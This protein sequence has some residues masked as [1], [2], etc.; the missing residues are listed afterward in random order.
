MTISRRAM[1]RPARVIEVDQADEVSLRIEPAAQVIVTERTERVTPSEPA[2]LPVAAPVPARRRDRVVSLALAGV[3][4]FFVGWL[5]VDALA[6]IAA[7]FERGTALGLL[8][9][10]AV[11]AGVAGAGAVIARE[12]Q[13]VPAQE[14][15]EAIHQ[16]LAGNLDRLRRP[17]RARRLPTCWRWCRASARSRPRSRRSSG[18]GHCIHS[19]G[20]QIE[21]LSR[22]VMTPLDRRAEAHVRTAVL[23]AFGITAISPTALTDA[24]FFLACG[25]RMVRGIASAYGHRPTA[26]ST[27][28]GGWSTRPASSAPSTSPAPAWCNTSAARSPSGSPPARPMRSTPATGWRGSASSSWICAGRFRSARTRFQC[29]LAGRQ[30][31]APRTERSLPRGRSRMRRN[32]MRGGSGMRSRISL[33][34]IRTTG[35]VRRRNVAPATWFHFTATA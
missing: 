5:A 13:P 28:C 8:A 20:Q 2:Y 18:E 31:A 24:A 29:R 11:A 27:C 12:S 7:A 32:V 17:R 33:R 3:A 30:R 25:V 22:T 10:A 35:V 6:W 26:A 34:S 23:R 4:V 14:H 9:A 1:A 15:V 16:R 19:A 21:L